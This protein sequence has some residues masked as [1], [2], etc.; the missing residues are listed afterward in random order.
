MTESRLQEMRTTWP[1]W[2]VELCYERACVSEYDGGL[3]REAADDVAYRYVQ[4]LLFRGA[5]GP[6]QLRGYP[7]SSPRRSARVAEKHG[8]TYIAGAA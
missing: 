3:D 8:T 1:A 4:E 6:Y 5:Q 2:A 7:S